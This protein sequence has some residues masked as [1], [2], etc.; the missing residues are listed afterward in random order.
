[1][2]QIVFWIKISFAGGIIA[3]IAAKVV[4]VLDTLPWEN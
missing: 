3:E 4:G 2:K 1:M